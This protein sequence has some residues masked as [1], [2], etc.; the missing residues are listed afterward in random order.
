VTNRSNSSPCIRAC[1]SSC[2]ITFQ[3]IFCF[4]IIQNFLFPFHLCGQWGLLRSR[5]SLQSSC[6][7]TYK[8]FLGPRC[9]IYS[10]ERCRQRQCRPNGEDKQTIW[11]ALQGDM[12]SHVRLDPQQARLICAPVSL[13]KSHESFMFY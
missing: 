7:F 13:P 4:P 12:I 10:S 9:H 2:I 11:E 5:N 3:N 6:H 1:S 8:S